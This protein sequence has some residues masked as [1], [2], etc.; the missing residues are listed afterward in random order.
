M[1]NTL[2]TIV[3][4]ATLFNAESQDEFCKYSN[5][6]ISISVPCEW[7]K[8]KKQTPIDLLNFVY[9]GDMVR[10]TATLKSGFLS[11]KDAAGII[12]EK[13]IKMLSN[14]RGN[15]VSFQYVN[16]NGVKGGE[17]IKKTVMKVDNGTFYFYTISN[18]VYY[19]EKLMII[20][21]SIGARNK[22][23]NDS[24]SIYLSLFRKLVQ[25]TSF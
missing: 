1:K 6:S 15:F 4:I 11:E 2:L 16:I 18:Y 8:Y 14:E 19:K 24:Y 3:F 20:E 22:V 17:I 7:G 12:S 23:F 21:Y 13:G 10:V 5:S 9:E 25:K